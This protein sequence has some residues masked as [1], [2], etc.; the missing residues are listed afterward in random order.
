MSAFGS[1]QTLYEQMFFGDPIRTPVS[2]Y[3]SYDKEGAKGKVA[4][5]LNIELEEE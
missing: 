4:S 2:L 5:F 1:R 3:A